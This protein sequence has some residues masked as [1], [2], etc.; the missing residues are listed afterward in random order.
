[1]RNVLFLGL[2]GFCGLILSVASSA[3]NDGA[4]DAQVNT[5][6]QEC[7]DMISSCR[8]EGSKI[9]Y[10]VA[11]SSKQ[12]KNVELFLFLAK[13]YQIAISAKKSAASVTVKFYDAAPDVKERKLIKEYKAVN[14][15]AFM[16]SSDELNKL[17]RKKAPEVERLKNIHVEY[18]I[19]TGKNVKEAAV[20]VYGFKA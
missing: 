18:S 20:L 15:K 19:G 8:Y 14:G 17:Y 9:T 10:Y 2:I 3:P 13:E 7:K 5:M 1:M 6:K 11:G 16:V 4:F 12:T